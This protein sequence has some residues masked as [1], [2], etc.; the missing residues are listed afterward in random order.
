MGTFTYIDKQ[1]KIDHP[2]Y[3]TTE[4]PAV[5]MLFSLFQFSQTNLVLNISLSLDMLLGFV[6]LTY[7]K[8]ET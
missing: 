5:N 1:G 2:K 4:I 8:R 7:G 3:T 6:N